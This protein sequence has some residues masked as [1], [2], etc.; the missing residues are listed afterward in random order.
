MIH[1]NEIRYTAEEIAECLTDHPEKQLLV[2]EGL[3]RLVDLMISAADTNRR[4][5]EGK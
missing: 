3:V 2:A 1:S 5:G 4:T